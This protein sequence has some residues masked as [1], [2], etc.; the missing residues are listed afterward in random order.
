MKIMRCLNNLGMLA[1][2][3]GIGVAVSLLFP[4]KFIAILVSFIVIFLSYTVI[5][6]YK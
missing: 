4:D 3:F 1:L 2:S 6:C 5:N